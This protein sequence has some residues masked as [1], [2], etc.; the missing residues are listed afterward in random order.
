[1]AMN[2]RIDQVRIELKADIAAAR[3]DLALTEHR[4]LTR[5]GGL[6]VVLAGLLFAALRYTG[7]G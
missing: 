3:A 5:L 2:A 1:V 6:M 4:L 7:H